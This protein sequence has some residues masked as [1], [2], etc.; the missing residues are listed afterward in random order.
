MKALFLFAL[1]I[2]QLALAAN[3][4]P[5]SSFYRSLAE[6]G[7]AEVDLGKLASDKAADPSVKDFGAMMVKDHSAANQELKSLAASKNVSL[8]DGPGVAAQAKKAKLE[9]LSGSTFDKAYLA[10]QIKAHQSTVTL[11]QTEIS[12]G[13]DPDAKAFAQ[14][15]LPTV[16]SHLSAAEKIADSLRIKSHQ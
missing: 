2:P 9:A 1:L 11:L 6:G 8:P 5:D 15:V 4:S 10:N 12:S 7:M 16:Q 14:K 3:G 13:K